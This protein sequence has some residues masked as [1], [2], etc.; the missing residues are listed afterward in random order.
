MD[1]KINLEPPKLRLYQLTK[2][3]A[4]KIA[5]HISSDLRDLGVIFDKPILSG[6]LI[7]VGVYSAGTAD[8]YY[9]TKNE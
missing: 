2:N 5:S 3:L 4:S 7:L 8:S 6:S 9:G 1:K